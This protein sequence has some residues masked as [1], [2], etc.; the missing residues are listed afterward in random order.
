MENLLQRLDRVSVYQSV[1]ARYCKEAA[2][3]I[4]E[5]RELL[6]A[7]LPHISCHTHDQCNIITAIGRK[8]DE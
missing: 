8:L 5:L 7:A 3:E 2:A 4:R 6:Q 1:C